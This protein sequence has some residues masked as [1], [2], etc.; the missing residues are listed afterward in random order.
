MRSLPVLVLSSLLFSTACGVGSPSEQ[1]TETDKLTQLKQREAWASQDNPALF[2]TQLDYT[3]DTLPLQGEA[4]NVPWAG[5]YWPTYQDNIN[6]QWAGSQSSSPAKKYELAFGG[7]NV[8]D[9]VSANHGIDG[10]RSQKVCKETSECNSAKSETCAKRTGKEEGRCIPTWWGICHAWTPAAIL[11][12]E[13]KLPV[14]RNGVTFEVADL[15]ALGSLVF[16]STRT[17]FVSLR[18]NKD[19]S[20]IRLD[21]YGR[22]IEGDRECRDTNAGTYHVLLANYLGKMRQAFAEDRIDDLEVWNQPLRGYKVTESREV[23]G[24]E[25]NRLVGVTSSPDA[26]TVAYKFNSSAVR[27]VSVRLEVRYITEASASSGYVGNNIDWYTR[28]DRYQYVLE[29]DRQGKIIGG[30]WVGSSKSNHPDFLWLPLGPSGSTVAGGAISFDTVK[31]MVLESSGTQGTPGPQVEV[32]A[33]ATIAKDEWKHFGPFSTSVGAITVDM[34]GTGDA[35]LYVRMNGQPT[36]ELYD[37]RPYGSDSAE[38]CEL[39]GP[40]PVSVSVHG[41]SAAEVALKIR[42]ASAV[43]DAGVPS[44][45]DAGTPRRDAGTATDAGR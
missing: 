15:K 12:P 4:A 45:G 23:S 3:F 22:P 41:Y 34:T 7:T 2:T 40:G 29:L 21:E 37:C 25:A 19:S 30:E 31:A 36:F 26:G 11:L 24:D 18:C 28:T 13:P 44:P 27:F 10:M 32:S 5:S 1:T 43:V 33:S 38:K 17:K 20:T 6:Y 16:N 35:D 39:S 14:V 42:Y 9:K 8:E